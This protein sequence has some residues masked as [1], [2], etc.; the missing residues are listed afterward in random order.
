MELIVDLI[1]LNNLSD[2][3]G[4]YTEKDV[5]N[6]SSLKQIGLVLIIYIGFAHLFAWL[7]V[8]ISLPFFLFG[9]LY[10]VYKR[11]GKIRDKELFTELENRSL[12][13]EQRVEDQIRAKNNKVET[14][15]N[16]LESNWLKAREDNQQN[17][18][19]PEKDIV[20]KD[21]V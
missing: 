4:G 21:G 11:L 8:I 3:L 20:T 16:K 17:T 9:I 18:T 10:R 7:V 5:E 14:R 12:I 2:L 13:R 19:K 6:L 1:F 15:L